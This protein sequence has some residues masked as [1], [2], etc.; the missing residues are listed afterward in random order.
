MLRFLL[1]LLGVDLDYQIAEIRA[2]IEQFRA[3]TTR[4]LAEQAKKTGLTIGFAA[5]GGIAAIATFVIVLVALYRWAD[6]YGGPFA[7]L[8][9][10]GMVTGLLAAV[11]FVLA[12]WR[13]P[14]NPASAGVDGGRAAAPAPP[15]G[16]TPRPRP[17]SALLA[18]ALPS[19]PS[20]ASVVDVLKHRV[21]T[22]VA[23]AGDEAVD[24]AVHLMRTGSR[25]VLFG[26]LAV[27]AL[28]G[29]LLGRRR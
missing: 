15:Q 26:T 27:V 25:S 13:G 2:Q 10:V 29:V 16:P 18:A 14:R 1:R 11:M 19:L 5:V 6:L 7:G 23:G 12:F 8:A 24:A 4:E 17:P 20:N 3:R 21:S 9:A 28:V 22:H